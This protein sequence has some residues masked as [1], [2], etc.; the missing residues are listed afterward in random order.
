MLGRK[1][2]IRGLRVSVG[3]IVGLLASGHSHDQGIPVLQKSERDQAIGIYVSC[4]SA[5]ISVINNGRFLSTIPQT[6]AA[7]T[8]E[9]P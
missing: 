3:T 6:T 1:P 9:Y 4:K 5:R 8:S 7:E 2:R